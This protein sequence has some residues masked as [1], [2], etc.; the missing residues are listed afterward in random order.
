MS[1]TNVNQMDPVKDFFGNDFEVGDLALTART[2][3]RGYTNYAVLLISGR[4]EKMVRVMTVGTHRQVEAEEI[5]RYV[6][7]FSSKPRAHGAVVPPWDLVKIG[8]SGF[9]PVQVRQIILDK[10]ADI[11]RTNAQVTSQHSISVP[12]IQSVFQQAASNSLP[13]I[14]QLRGSVSRTSPFIFSTGNP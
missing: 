8:N 7:N 5:E 14:Q 11:Q 4:T 2:T 6:A 12:N 13:T 9:S 10:L 3:P 1:N